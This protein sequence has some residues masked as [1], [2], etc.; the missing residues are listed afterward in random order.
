MARASALEDVNTGRVACLF[1]AARGADDVAG[2]GTFKTLAPGV[3]YSA[4]RATPLV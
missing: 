1:A 2:R 4:A 3:D